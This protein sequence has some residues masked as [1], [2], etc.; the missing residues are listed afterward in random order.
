MITDNREKLT[1]CLYIVRTQAG[2]KQAAKEFWNNEERKPDIKGYPKSY[3]ALVVFSD[4]Y[5]G[6]W[7][8]RAN[9]YALNFITEAIARHEKE[10]A[11]GHKRPL[12]D[13]A[14]GTGTVEVGQPD[15]VGRIDAP[16][17]GDAGDI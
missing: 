15:N 17:I 16:E 2:F 6:Y 3:P 10:H 4:G 8:V 7:Y 9:C 5:E 11:S 1:P 13:E 12:S 14:T